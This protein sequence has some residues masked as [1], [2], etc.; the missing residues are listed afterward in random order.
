MEFVVIYIIPLE[1][2]DLQQLNQL[3][4]GEWQKMVAIVQLKPLSNLD[5]FSRLLT[6]Y[7]PTAFCVV[8]ATHVGLTSLC[9]VGNV[10]LC[11]VHLFPTTLFYLSR[12]L[13]MAQNKFTAYCHNS[14]CFASG[15]VV[16]V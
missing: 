13:K 15:Q 2:S 8:C 1:D 4:K 11:C 9:D 7:F 5:P 3:A 14:F 10:M 12:L 16:I 6:F